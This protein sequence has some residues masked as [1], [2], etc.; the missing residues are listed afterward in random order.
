MK[1]KTIITALLQSL[2]LGINHIQ[3][4]LVIHKHIAGQQIPCFVGSVSETTFAVCLC[5]TNGC[6]IGVNHH[7]CGRTGILN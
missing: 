6:H 1:K 7:L 2:Y 3:I 4:P 5:E